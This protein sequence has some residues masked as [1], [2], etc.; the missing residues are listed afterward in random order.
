MLSD[1]LTT[2]LA[3]YAI[4]PKIR[5]MRLSRKLGLT[6]LGEHTGLSPALLSKIER[7]QIFPTLPTLLRI[8]LVF[9]VGLEHFFRPDAERP[10]VA[11]ARKADRIRLPERPGR[12]SPAYFFESLDYPVSDR[13]L[14]GYYVEMESED[15]PSDPHVHPGAELVFVLQGE[16]VINVAGEDHTLRRGDAIYFDCA[17]PHTYRRNGRSRCAAIVVVTGYESRRSAEVAYSAPGQHRSTDER[18]VAN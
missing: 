14:N 17:N 8:A 5:T 16:L 18:T 10:L 6:Q 2:A 12:A 15:Q 3:S 11:V 9:G 4:G 1:T 13:K 7:G